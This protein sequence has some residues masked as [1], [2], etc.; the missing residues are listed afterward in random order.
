MVK[1]MAEPIM[2]IIGEPDQGDINTLEQELDETTAKM[3]TTEDVVEKG[4][5]YGF[6]VVGFLKK[7]VWHS[8]WESSSTSTQ[9]KETLFD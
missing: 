7:Q 8:H 9:A 2:K 6:L 1:L 3:K 5:K 4:C